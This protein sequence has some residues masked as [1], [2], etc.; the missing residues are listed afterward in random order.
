MPRWALQSTDVRN[1]HTYCRCCADRNSDLVCL[2]TPFTGNEHPVTA[3]SGREEWKQ[4]SLKCESRHEL[5]KMNHAIAN[6]LVPLIDIKA[7]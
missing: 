7:V 2:L 3:Q 6:G 5:G 4:R 1:L